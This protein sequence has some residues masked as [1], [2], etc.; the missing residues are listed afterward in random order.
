MTDEPVRA[1]DPKV[2]KPKKSAA[3]IP[4]ITHALQYA[5]AEMGAI[6]SARTLLK[7]NHVDGFDCP[8]CAW[9]DPDR[10]HAAEFCENG[11]KAV[12]WEATRKR[13]GPDFFA[14]NSIAELRQ[15]PDHWLEHNGRLTEP[16]Y[17]APGA[18]HYAPIAWD[19]ALRLVADRLRAM[20]DPNR[21]VLSTSGR[22][23]DEAAFAYQLLARRLG[24]NNLPDCSNMCHESSGAALSE[25]IGIGKGTVTMKDIAEEA[26]LIVIVG[27]NPGTNHPR[28]LSS[29]EEAKQRGAR[30][31]AVNPLPEAGLVKFRNPQTPRGL[32]GP[33]TDIADRYLPVRVNGDH[34]LFAGINLALLERDDRQ[35]GVLDTDF[36]ERYTDGFATA[37]SHWRSLS[38]ATIER[39]SGHTSKQVEDFVSDVVAADRIVVC[40]AMGL[41]QHRNSVATIREIVNFL[42]L[43]GNIGKPGAGASPIRGHS[44]VQGDRT[45]GIWERMRDRF[46]DALAAE[47]GF[48]RPRTHGLDSVQSIEAM[49]RGEIK[50]WFA[51]GGNLV[52]AISDTAA[53]EAAMRGTELTVQ[54]STKLNRSHVV[55]SAEALILPTLGRTDVD[56]QA[57]GPQFVSVEDSV[58]A[59]HATHGALP[60]VSP[61]LLSEVSIVTRLARAVLG[62][63]GPID[64]AG[65]ERDYDTIRESISH[66]VPGFED[67][68]RQVRRRGGFV[69]PNGP[70][71]SR[72]FATSTGKAMLTVNQLVPVECPPGR[73]ILQT[74]RSHDQFNTT[75]YGLNDRYRG[76]HRGRDVL[77]VS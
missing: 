66:V 43:R 52:A 68:N 8:S 64:W 6:R 9:P 44:N 51:L 2:G 28:M 54:V 24:T 22:A 26:D 76:I 38:W 53:A 17:L 56:L 72:T 20:P 46:L 31:V 15:Q 34:A 58:C 57:T 30:I 62:D 25:T 74:M 70:R 16:M 75:M 32:A 4:G 77:F 47:F 14:D 21:A 12:A 19:D 39:Q 7:M 50:V 18:T 1:D 59:V 10:R 60:P 61:M 55:T 37:A 35:G 41:T 27:Q 69:L 40:W 49:Q 3:G 48:E 5:W 33:G 42:L 67:F 63:D 65:F 36:I 13:V 11:A 73:L 71:D 29:L 23:S 45:M